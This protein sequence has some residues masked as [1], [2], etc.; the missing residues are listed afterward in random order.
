MQIV[1]HQLD[2]QRARE[3]QF[4]LNRD[5]PTAQLGAFARP[6][7]LIAEMPD[8]SGLSGKIW[9][10]KWDV[11]IVAKLR[12]I[13]PKWFEQ[14][15]EKK[16]DLGSTGGKDRLPLELKERRWFTKR[17]PTTGSDYEQLRTICSN[18]KADVDYLKQRVIAIE[19]G[20]LWLFCDVNLRALWLGP[21]LGHMAEERHL[22]CINRWRGH[23]K[24]VTATW[25]RGY[26][27]IEEFT[28]RPTIAGRLVDPQLL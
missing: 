9:D 13:R 23:L 15:A 11:P 10:Y 7:T 2:Q 8:L 16:V 3:R 6:N 26:Q 14:D 25:A 22:A 27:M 5:W 12:Q 28:V 17:W 19:V 20:M 1:P 24:T 21:E 4:K 18:T